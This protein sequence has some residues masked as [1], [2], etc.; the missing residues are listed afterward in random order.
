L[1]WKP[2]GHK[3]ASASAD[4][5][6]RLWACGLPMKGTKGLRI[7]AKP[8]ATLVGHTGAVKDVQWRPSGY[9]LASAG[10]VSFTG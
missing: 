2:Y 10:E 7:A 1:A 4:G 8:L 5:T 9:S 6:I 3:L